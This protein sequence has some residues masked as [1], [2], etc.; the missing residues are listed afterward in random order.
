MF[1]L[2]LHV[3]LQDSGVLSLLFSFLRMNTPRSFHESGLSV[4]Q[5]Q[6]AF[7]RQILALPKELLSDRAQSIDVQLLI[8]LTLREPFHQKMT[9]F[10]AFC[11]LVGKLA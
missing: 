10:L 8:T 11:T 4:P 1:S 7:S 3:M 2:A 9:R 6:P 5:S